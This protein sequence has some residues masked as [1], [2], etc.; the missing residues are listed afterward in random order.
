MPYTH[1]PRDFESPLAAIAAFYGKLIGKWFG[2]KKDVFFGYEDENPKKPCLVLGC[3]NKDIALDTQTVLLLREALKKEPTL[4]DDY[5]DGWLLA[6]ADNYIP[7]STSSGSVKPTRR[8]GKKPTSTFIAKKAE[9][10]SSDEQ[11]F[12]DVSDAIDSV[13]GQGN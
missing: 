5:L 12:S 6:N 9:Q 3:G 8:L 4:L 1:N 2:Y 10:I 7:R 11:V 13:L